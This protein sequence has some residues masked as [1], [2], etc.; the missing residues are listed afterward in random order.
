[1]DMLLSLARPFITLAAFI[2]LSPLLHLP[3]LSLVSGSQREV[4]RNFEAA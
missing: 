1:M 3:F 4:G 2:L